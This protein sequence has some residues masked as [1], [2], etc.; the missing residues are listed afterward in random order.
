MAKQTARRPRPLVKLADSG[1][2]LGDM[3]F[4]E[5]FSNIV[6]AFISE[7]CPR[8]L[9]YEVGFQL[10][11]RDPKRNRAAAVTAFKAG[12]L[13]LLSPAFFVDGKLLC[14]SLYVKNQDKYVPFKE[15]WVNFLL[16]KKP[17]DSG[18]A[19]GRSLR[20][21]GVRQPDIANLLS[22][23]YKYASDHKKLHDIKYNPMKYAAYK[24]ADT[25]G[26]LVEW[27]GGERAALA[28]EAVVIERRAG[29]TGDDAATFGRLD[30]WAKV[31]SASIARTL[32]TLPEFSPILPDLIRKGG[33]PIL[34]KLAA[35]ADRYP[36]LQQGLLATYG[37]EMLSKAASE[38]EDR[39]AAKP[40]F[41][42]RAVSKSAAAYTFN[43]PIARGRL[44]VIRADEVSAGAAQLFTPDER[45]TLLVDGVLIKDARDDDEVSEAYPLPL[46]LDSGIT[47]S[48]PAESGIYDVLT[49]DGDYIKCLVVLAP[50]NA[51][52]NA[53]DCVV[54]DL[55]GGR[56]ATI[57]HP[58][59]VMVNARYA[60]W[61]AWFEK[62]PEADDLSASSATRMLISSDG[63]ASMP[64]SVRRSAGERD[65]RKGYVVCFDASY[66]TE[67]TPL[68]GPGRPGPHP[69]S[70]YGG[71]PSR[72]W[73]E[74]PTAKFMARGGDLIAPV[75]AR[76]LEVD[77]GWNERGEADEYKG[78]L[79]LGKSTDID[80]AVMARTK[81][82]TV[83]VKKSGIVIN[84]DAY[85]ADLDARVALI[86]GHGFRADSADAILKY[87]A[88]LGV[89]GG[90]LKLR[91]KRADPGQGNYGGPALG[92][93]PIAPSFP[94][95]QIYNNGYMGHQGASHGTSQGPS[96]QV[97]P[98]QDLLNIPPNLSG[99]GGAD[100]PESA[101]S[102]Q[103]APQPDNRLIG[104]AQQAS[105][106]GQREVVDAS[107][108]GS[109]LRATSDAKLIDD[110]IDPLMT[111]LD[112]LAKLDIAGAWHPERLE[113]RYGKANAQ[114]IR[115][116]VTNNF[117][118]LGD[119]VLEL[120]LKTIE[121]DPTAAAMD[122]DIAANQ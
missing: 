88:E 26:S 68:Y 57:I 48:N 9:D 5:A 12:A 20:T 65:G 105:Q 63:T 24:V 60:G 106:Q 103:D 16:S 113:D 119:L 91:V 45:T 67:S 110:H 56:P 71:D 83:S 90:I 4:E 64:F 46:T 62:L 25:A 104:M 52:G 80:A 1:T 32:T 89:T 36:I 38:I 66:G 92:Q 76:V 61:Q 22:S 81:P 85:A 7:K 29:L 53:N 115:E 55:K 77:K 121:A 69:F 13:W 95:E 44:E 19:A 59:R 86:R 117:D 49:R 28:A 99:Y 17:S 97:L 78:P 18:D 58:S 112:S 120:R 37:A 43:D 50:Y 122:N 6:H 116:A 93:G 11:R 14:S 31:A 21:L 84:S 96:E 8:L 54:V 35:L 47:L 39:P 94:E 70:G 3:P 111:A 114:D 74:G 118:T 87:A 107:V 75:G 51:R 41:R 102:P 72:I 100:N 40:K 27:T 33:L 98:V 34:E 73:L 30:A 2:N 101:S 15:N 10:L 109:L 42:L 23:P 108:V 79:S 82:L